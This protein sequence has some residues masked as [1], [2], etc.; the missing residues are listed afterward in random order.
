M[1]NFKESSTSNPLSNFVNCI[2]FI[3]CLIFGIYII[4]SLAL[5]PNALLLWQYHSANSVHNSSSTIITSLEHIAFGIAASDKS[6]SRRKEYVRLW[7]RP[8]VMKGCVFLEQMPPISE[9]DRVSLPPICISADTSRFKYTNKYGRRSAIRVARV[10]SETVALMNNNSDVRWFVFG[11]DDTVFFPDNLVK[12][13]Q[14]YDHGLWYYIGTNSEYFETNKGN[15]FEMAF[16]GAGFAISSP[17][18]KVLG[19]VL[20]SCLIR[21]HGV[22]GSD[23]RIHICLA[24][25]GV[26]LT[27]EPGFHQMD[28]KGNIFGLLTA[29]PIRPLISLHHID[30]LY[31]IFPNMRSLEALIQLVKAA[32]ADPERILQ[33]TVCYDQLSSTFSVSWGY[34]IQQW[35][36]NALLRDIIRAQE[37]YIPWNK[38]ENYDVDTQRYDPNPCKR[39]D[40]FFFDSVSSN[41]DGT[42]SI[43]KKADRNC[44]KNKNKIDVIRVSSKKLD[45]NAKQMQAPRRQCCDVLQ[46]SS[47]ARSS[48]IDIGIRECGA[49]ELIQMKLQE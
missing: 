20:D 39:P 25:L 9:N 27:H 10:V 15:S 21:Y 23:A 28:M 32:K 38:N 26:S 46:S 29:H 17:L 8:E 6:W 19:K 16:G 43:Y 13:L 1:K 3:S 2:V 48:V 31:P 40:V 7:W 24:E 41:R 34:A 30:K 11:D 33:Q 14:K 5:V 36:W 4:L 35:R 12:T 49:E 18:A 47:S 45:L 37:T 44:T 22:Y 42:T